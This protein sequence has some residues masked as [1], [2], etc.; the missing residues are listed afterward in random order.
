MEKCAEK[1]LITRASIVEEALQR[2]LINDQRHNLLLHFF[3]IQTI[4]PN[5]SPTVSEGSKYL[6][7][8]LRK[9]DKFTKQG[10][11]ETSLEHVM[12]IVQS[13]EFNKLSDN[14]KYSQISTSKAVSQKRDFTHFISLPLNIQG[15]IDPYESWMNDILLQKYPSIQK[16]SF[17][18]SSMLHL[19]ILMLPLESPDQLQN[20]IIAFKS[21]E[22][23]IK[24]IKRKLSL[25]M[26][27]PHLAFHS[28]QFMGKP[29]KARVVYYDLD[30]E[31]PWYEAL[32]D[33]IDI[34]IRAMLKFDV[35][36]ESEL[37][38][39]FFNEETGRYENEKL[40]VTLM[41][42]TFTKSKGIDLVP[43]IEDGLMEE[44][45]W[46]PITVGRIDISTRFKYGDDGFYMPAYSFYF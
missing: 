3:E 30:V 12:I 29:S 17:T 44:A 5:L 42:S 38:H 19:T 11:L 41:N 2:G 37:S 10:D 21:V 15:L 20:A 39:I 36:Q 9:L 16:R 4:D 6:G 13:K 31:S 34:L 27:D 46:D 18:S 45:Y 23:T 25:K 35:L 28:L 24:E 22:N 43:I 26:Q 33:A 1:F 32:K 14:Y 40:H 8:I 7:N